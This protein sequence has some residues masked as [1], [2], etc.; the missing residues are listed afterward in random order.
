MDIYAENILDH[1]KNP[2][3]HG[4]LDNASVAFKGSNPLCGDK[5]EVELKVDDEG[6][7]TDAAFL[8]AGCAISRASTSMLMDEIIGKPLSYI[9]EL[10]SEKVFE[11]MGIPLTGTRIKCA[12][13]SL[14]VIKRAAEKYAL[15]QIGQ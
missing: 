15:D 11:I 10:T 2:R 9:D 14:D 4:K 13:L 8:G 5:I 12:L 7:I 1:N 6:V 3:H